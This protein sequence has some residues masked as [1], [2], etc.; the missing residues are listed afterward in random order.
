MLNYCRPIDEHYSLLVAGHGDQI[1]N[2]D[3]TEIDNKDESASCIC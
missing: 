1:T 2:L 3:G